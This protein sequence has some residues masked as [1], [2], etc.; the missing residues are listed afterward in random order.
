[1]NSQGRVSASYAEEDESHVQ[2]SCKDHQTTWPRG[3]GQLL[4]LENDEKNNK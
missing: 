2:L 3:K 1:M 4:S